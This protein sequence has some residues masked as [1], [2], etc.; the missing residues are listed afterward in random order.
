MR[1]NPDSAF[2]DISLCLR[3]F[4]D[5]PLAKRELIVWQLQKWGVDRLLFSSDHITLL[6]FPT[7]GQAL[8]TLSKYPFTQEEME[9][10]TS[11]D[12]SAWLKG[13]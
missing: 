13:K 10:L 2:L 12:A 11:N 5:A 3:E 7:P 1:P 4:E 8:E 9:L 6:G